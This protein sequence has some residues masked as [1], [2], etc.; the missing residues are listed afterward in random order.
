MKKPT[1]KTILI[2]IALIS[3]ALLT[4]NAFAENTPKGTVPPFEKPTYQ[5]GPE[6]SDSDRADP[7]KY[8]AAS[9]DYF[10]RVVARVTN[11]FLGIVTSAALLML[12]VSGIQMLTAYGEEEK[13]TNAKKTALWSIVGLVIAILAYAIVSIIVSLPFTFLPEA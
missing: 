3:G 12:I 1:L 10:I 7:A 2:A 5:N 9:Q 11:G 6:Y 4:Q 8:A 13:I